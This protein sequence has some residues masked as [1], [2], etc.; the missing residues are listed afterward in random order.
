MAPD[1][2]AASATSTAAQPAAAPSAKPA[3]RYDAFAI[4]TG[5]KYTATPEALEAAAVED[6]AV[7]DPLIAETPAQETPEP[8]APSGEVTPPT[9]TSED[10]PA[11]APTETPAATPEPSAEQSQ[12]IA[13]LQSQ[14][15]AA[16][17][18]LGKYKTAEAKAAAA[19]KL[20]KLRASA[21]A[22]KEQYGAETAMGAFADTFMEF[23]DGISAQA[24]QTAAAEAQRS[25]NLMHRT[26]MQESP[27]VEKIYETLDADGN[28]IAAGE[29]Y[30]LINAISAR[31]NSDPKTK[32][33]DQV[34]H[35]KAIEAAL[36]KRE[37]GIRERYFP[38]P[39]AV[40]APAAPAVPTTKVAG[41]TTASDIPG[42]ASPKPTKPMDPSNM[43][44]LDLVGFAS[45][46]S[47]SQFNHYRAERARRR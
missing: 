8:A 21:A 31:L 27:I 45:N 2:T 17:A 44:I 28:H 43:G 26:A 7:A 11:E 46:A 16:K 22:L 1:G 12:A 18:E 39:A 35:Y 9:P 10:A 13:D 47:D 41:P 23:A 36:L 32:N 40:A 30:A 5:G 19:A 38:K 37:P 15:D 20:Q 14:L 33:L 34:G 6:A 4:A 29:D 42:G 25:D 24:E 3:T